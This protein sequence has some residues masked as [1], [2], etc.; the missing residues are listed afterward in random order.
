MRRHPLKLRYWPEPR[1]QDES[2]QVLD[3]DWEWI[4]A[5]KGL[6]IGELRIHETIAGFDNW[7]VIFF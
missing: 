5:C 6:R 7:R 2:G 3:L 1:P 4:K